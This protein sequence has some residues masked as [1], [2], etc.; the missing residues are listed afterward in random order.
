M[1]RDFGDLEGFVDA[2]ADRVLGKL[3]RPT[4]PGPD[5]RTPAATARAALGREGRASAG[6]PSQASRPGTGTHPIHPI[7][8]HWLW[9]GQFRA[10]RGAQAAGRARLPLCE[11]RPARR[12]HA[13]RQ[14][15]HRRTRAVPL[16]QGSLPDRPDSPRRRRSRPENAA[17]SRAFGTRNPPSISHLADLESSLSSS[18]RSRGTRRS[19]SRCRPGMCAP[20]RPLRWC[21]SG[22]P[23]ARAA[24]STASESFQVIAG[25]RAEARPGARQLEEHGNQCRHLTERFGSAR[26]VGACGA[27][28]ALSLFRDDDSGSRGDQVR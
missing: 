28:A 16:G 13:V 21:G 22:S 2:I 7:L 12:R 11:R 15:R 19:I 14:D 17:R 20:A 10:D 5:R 25:Q 26:P 18:S 4:Q 27:D 24:L 23:A 8:W 1:P 3:T 9:A 6:V